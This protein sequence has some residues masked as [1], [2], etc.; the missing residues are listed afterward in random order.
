L[1]PV[2]DASVIVA[3][4]SPGE[5]QH[6]RARSLFELQPLDT[7]YV[8][9]ALFRIEVVAAF[10]RRGESDALLDAVDALVR[11]PRFHTVALEADLLDLALRV[12][13]RARLRAYDA[14][15]GALALSRGESLYTLDR[16]VERRLADAF[17]EITVVTRA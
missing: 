8:V 2:L 12:G 10:A 17:P 11:G 9:P 4:L 5:T 1:S 16:E 15:Y 7:P 6:A 14:V 13:R 3:A